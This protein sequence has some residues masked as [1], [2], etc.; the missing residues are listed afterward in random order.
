MDSESPTHMN[1]SRLRIIGPQMGNLP[2]MKVCLLSSSF[3]TRAVALFE[4]GFVRKRSY[5]DDSCYDLALSKST[6]VGKSS[7]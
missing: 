1:H 6:C 2:A 7:Y 4:A 5:L 3:S